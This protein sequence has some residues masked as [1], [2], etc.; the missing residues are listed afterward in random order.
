MPLAFESLALVMHYSAELPEIYQEV[1]NQG[2]VLLRSPPSSDPHLASDSKSHTLGFGFPHLP[3]TCL[4]ERLRRLSCFVE[5][6]S[7]TANR[8]GVEEFSLELVRTVSS[9]LLK[10]SA[11]LPPTVLLK[12]EHR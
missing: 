10:L 7:S 11:M 3:V 9:G 6:S 8:A 5:Q 1:R 12:V 2:L 4:F